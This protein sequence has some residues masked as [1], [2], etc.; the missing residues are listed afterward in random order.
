MDNNVSEARLTLEKT[1]KLLRF[2]LLVGVVLIHCDLSS[3]YD[4]SSDAISFQIMYFFSQVIC[5]ICVPIYFMMSG[6][7]FF[8]KLNGVFDKNIYLGKLSKRIRT[9]LIPYLLWNFVGFLF[10]VMKIC[11]P[12]FFPGLVGMEIELS[13]FFESFWDFKYSEE[14]TIFNPN[15]PAGYPIDF[16]LWFLRDL[17]VLNLIT[18]LIY[19]AVK[20][21]KSVFPIVLLVLFIGNIWCYG[22]V[23]LD[24][25]G[26]TFYSIGAY[27]SLN[28][29]NPVNSLSKLR[30]MPFLYIVIAIVDVLTC[31]ASYNIFI[32]RLGIVIGSVS[33]LVIAVALVRRKLCGDSREL[34]NMGF[35]TYV[36]HG[37][38]M[39]ILSGLLVSLT[40][41]S[42][43]AV[44]IIF[45]FALLS[46]ALAISS[47]CYGLCKKIIP[48]LLSISIG[49]R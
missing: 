29:L 4:L 8:Y 21:L 9:L 5:R 45:Y 30:F 23:G 33:C 24:I 12:R 19:W 43:D 15:E 35:F 14:V 48:R 36:F 28:D 3:K 44:I 6:F 16:P 37:L 26:L 7:L 2:P 47:A 39:S 40:P 41:S 25:T 18:P 20:L 10:L 17:I 42:S 22:I 38:I 32:H 34:A 11:L 46:L 1:I 27:F 49:G 13:T 31:N